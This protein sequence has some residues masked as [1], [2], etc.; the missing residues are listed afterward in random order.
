MPMGEDQSEAQHSRAGFGL[1]ATGIDTLSNLLLGALDLGFAFIAD[2]QLIFDHFIQPVA[3]RFH[4]VKWKFRAVGILIS[5]NAGKFNYANLLLSA[6]PAIL[7]L[8]PDVARDRYG[9]P[10]EAGWASANS[11]RVDCLT[12]HRLKAGLHTFQN[13]NCWAATPCHPRAGWHQLLRHPIASSTF[14]QSA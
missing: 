14:A 1:A 13:E 3:D 7:I 9:V 10:A 6:A 11:H 5:R 2:L 8:A 4:L 12:R